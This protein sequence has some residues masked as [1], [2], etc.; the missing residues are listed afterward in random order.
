MQI[1]RV[2]MI[3]LSLA[4]GIGVAAHADEPVTGKGYDF[5]AGYRTACGDKIYAPCLDQVKLL[6]GGLRQAKGEKKLALVIFGF[7]S[8]PPCNVLDLWLKSPQGGALM[9]SYVQVDLSIL[10]KGGAIRPEVF[11]SVLPSLKLSINQTPPY[12]V[13]LFAIINP[14]TQQVLGKAIVGFSAD[15]P[16]AHIAYLTAYAKG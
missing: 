13:P 12:G 6:N 4:I 11:S 7:D 2:L 10:D 16:Q 15:K 3:G 5:M 8:C 9:K 14:T 1:V